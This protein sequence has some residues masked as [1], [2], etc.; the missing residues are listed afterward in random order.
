MYAFGTVLLPLEEHEFHAKCVYLRCAV[1]EVVSMNT[2]VYNEVVSKNTIVYNSRCPTH[3]DEPRE[4]LVLAIKNSIVDGA[5]ISAHS[6]YCGLCAAIRNNTCSL[7]L[8]C[9]TLRLPK[10][11]NRTLA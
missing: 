9:L 1:N 7:A 8:Q 10:I 4:Y 6:M 11:G 2:I 5:G 3:F